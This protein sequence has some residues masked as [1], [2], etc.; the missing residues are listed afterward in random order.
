MCLPDGCVGPLHKSI[1]CL[2]EESTWVSDPRGLRPPQASRGPQAEPETPRK[3]TREAS[4]PQGPSKSPR[5]EGPRGP[6]NRHPTVPRESPPFL[7]LYHREGIRSS[8]LV[9]RSLAAKSELCHH[10]KILRPRVRQYLPCNLVPD[11]TG[12]TASCTGASSGGRALRAVWQAARGSRSEPLAIGSPSTNANGR[13]QTETDT[14]ALQFQK[15]DA[16][17]R[18]HLHGKRRAHRSPNQPATSAITATCFGR[19]GP[20]ARVEWGEPR[21]PSQG[22]LPSRTPALACDGLAG[23]AGGCAAV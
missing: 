8:Y 2:C 14:D 20:C 22:P 7:P 4:N 18:K 3:E 16:A 13:A 17:E 19:A 10:A 1:D 23:R 21:L 11:G 9:C 6:H 5:K 15:G 12:S